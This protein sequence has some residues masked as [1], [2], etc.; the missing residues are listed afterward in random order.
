MKNT[1]IL[2]SRRSIIFAS[3][4]LALTSIMPNQSLASF[5]SARSKRKLALFNTHTK[6]E[7]EV[8]YWRN[9]KY[10]EASMLKLNELL[11]DHRQESVIAIDANVIDQIFALQKRVGSRE[12]IDIISGYRSKTSNEELR[13]RRRG[14]A[15]RSYHTLGRAIDICI[16]DVGLRSQ[17]LAALRLSAGGVGYYPRSKFIHLDSGPVRAW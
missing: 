8:T 11:R 7:V 2:T 10:D 6:E 9:G 13:Q 16:P 15:K 4:A 3:G 5:L 12:R 1:D 14:V 17:R